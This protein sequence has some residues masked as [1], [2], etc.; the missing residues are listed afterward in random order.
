MCVDA[1]VVLGPLAG[2]VIGGVVS[3]GRFGGMLADGW[4]ALPGHRVLSLLATTVFYVLAGAVGGWVARLLRR[5]EREVA[6]TRA[7]EEAARTLY[8]GVLQTLALVE[9]R[10]ATADPDLARVARD[11]DRDLR[12]YLYGTSDAAHSDLAG[13][14]RRAA[15][16]VSAAFDLPVTVSVVDDDLELGRRATDAIVGAVGEA[17]TNAAKHSGATRAAVFAQRDDSGAVFVSVRD[18]GCGF[19]PAAV[20]DGAEGIRRSVIGRVEE[21]GGRVEIDTADGR[22]TEV[23]VWL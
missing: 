10:V 1:A 8:D 6:V 20:R 11:T 18:D 5:A 14:L 23:R 22:G 2:G 4:P 15:D 16:R 3:L 13:G 9:R 19:D 12:A 21:V 17:L 7:R